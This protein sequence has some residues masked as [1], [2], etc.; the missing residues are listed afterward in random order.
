MLLCKH[1]AGRIGVEMAELL[2]KSAIATLPWRRFNHYQF[3]RPKH[4]DRGHLDILRGLNSV[5]V[6]R[7]LDPPF[8]SN[9]N[10]ATPLR[11]PTGT[12]PPDAAGRKQGDASV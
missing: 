9:R 4:L 2:M 12:H 3:R 11:G 1:S 8:N 5:S 6:D 7:I 10:Y